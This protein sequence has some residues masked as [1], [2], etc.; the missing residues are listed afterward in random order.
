[1][2]LVGLVKA[3][4]LSKFSKVKLH[5]RSRSTAI[6]RCTVMHAQVVVVCGLYPFRL[7]PF[8]L[9]KGAYFLANNGTPSL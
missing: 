5:Q 1:M 9:M 6:S 8:R 4:L 2:N 7:I 3:N